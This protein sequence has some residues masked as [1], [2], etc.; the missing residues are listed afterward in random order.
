MLKMTASFVLA[1]LRGSTY[2]RG[3]ASPLRSLRQRWTA[4]LSLLPL[5]WHNHL[6]E[7]VLSR[8]ASGTVI[9]HLPG[10]NQIEGNG[11]NGPLARH[12]E[13]AY[14]DKKPQLRILIR[15]QHNDSYRLLDPRCEPIPRRHPPSPDQQRTAKPRECYR[16]RFASRPP[17]TSPSWYPLSPR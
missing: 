2:P 5:P 6:T 10:T 11:V 13:V 17:Q 4:I 1:S 9:T 14:T 16:P 8:S 15:D 3:Y 7:V 12:P